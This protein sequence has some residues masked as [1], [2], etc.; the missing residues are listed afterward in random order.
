MGKGAA[1]PT[2]IPKVELSMETLL[3]ILWYHAATRPRAH[4]VSRL[5][6]DRTSKEYL[7]LGALLSIAT[8]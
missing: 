3:P 5:V 6:D 4:I 7:M 1:F 2:P 8:Y